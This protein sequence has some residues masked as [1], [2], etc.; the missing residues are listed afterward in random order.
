MPLSPEGGRL[1]EERDIFLIH[2]PFPGILN[3]QS[4]VQNMAL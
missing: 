4:P 2:N 1:A 3:D